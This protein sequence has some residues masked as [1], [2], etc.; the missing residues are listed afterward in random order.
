MRAESAIARAMSIFGRPG[1]GRIRCS[2]ASATNAAAPPPTPLNSATI[3]GIAVIFTRR[4]A[5]APKPPPIAIAITIAHQLVLPALIQVTT[6][7]TIIPAAPIWLP[8][9]ACAGFDRKRSARMNATIG[10]R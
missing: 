2:S 10:I 9:R 1:S 7:A 8:R 5:T 3:C 4:A 6:I